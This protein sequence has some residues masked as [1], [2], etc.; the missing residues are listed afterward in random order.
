MRVCSCSGLTCSVNEG[1]YASQQ[2]TEMRP[3][4]QALFD[5][6]LERKATTDREARGGSP[7]TTALSND[8]SL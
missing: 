2:E 3:D 5:D 8:G 7:D 4:S 6:G 1:T